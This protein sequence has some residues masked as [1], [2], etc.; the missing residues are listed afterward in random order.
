MHLLYCCFY[1]KFTLW[2][3]HSGHALKLHCIALASFCSMKGG[4]DLSCSFIVVGQCF[5]STSVFLITL[6]RINICRLFYFLCFEQ[7]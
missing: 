5:I 4:F 2:S 7:K 1:I 6:D 3:A